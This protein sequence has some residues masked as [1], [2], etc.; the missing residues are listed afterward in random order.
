MASGS[1]ARR[2]SPARSIG[3]APSPLFPADPSAR[4]EVEAA[5][6]F[7]DAELQA[8]ARRILWNALRRD[9][10]PLRSY[11]AGARLGVPI[12][13]AMKTAAPIVALSARFNKADDDQV[14]ADIAAL[15]AMLQRI[16]DWVASGVLGGDE[17]NAADYQVAT[18]VR[19]MM[20]LDDLR[21]AIASRPAGALAMA[22]DPDYPGQAPPILPAEWLEPL[23]AATPA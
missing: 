11:S 4:A 23:R 14:R 20:T 10:R 18:S 21:P 3:S 16:D 8:V 7:G 19:L 22:I 5:E 13:L 17:P 9:R 15:P 1:R 2:R 12:G 6:D